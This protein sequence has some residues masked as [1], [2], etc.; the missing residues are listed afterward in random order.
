M[1]PPDISQSVEY[2]ASDFF[3]ISVAISGDTVL[4]GAYQED[5]NATG[6]N[7]NEFDNSAESSG[8]AFIYA[9]PTLLR[10]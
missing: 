1:E 3:G 2:E 6:S 7:G 9:P 4:A 10:K 5:S 8:A